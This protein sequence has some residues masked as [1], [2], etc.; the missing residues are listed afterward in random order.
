MALK[1]LI[2]LEA[3]SRGGV[4]MLDRKNR[5]VPH[6]FVLFNDANHALTARPAPPCALYQVSIT[7][8]DTT[9]GVVGGTLAV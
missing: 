7:M 4:R 8:R 9:G 3:T 6:E 1:N 2:E 5:M